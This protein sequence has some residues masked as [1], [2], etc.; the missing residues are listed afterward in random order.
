MLTLST[1]KIMGLK[2]TATKGDK[3]KKKEVAEEIAKLEHELE[4]RHQNEL[5]QFEALEET[6]KVDEVAND[7]EATLEV[8]TRVTKAQKRR[9]KKQIKD[10][11]RD[12][13]VAEQE[14]ANLQGARHL[15]TESIRKLLASRGLTFHDVPS[16]GHCMYVA[17]AHQLGADSPSV[18][19]LRKTAADF[20]RSHRDDFMPFMDNVVDDVQFLK[21]CQE[22][23]STAAWGGQLELRALSQGLGRAIEVLQSEGRPVLIGEEFLA[24]GKPT[25]TLTYHRHMFGLGEHYNSVQPLP[26]ETDTCD[27]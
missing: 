2:K 13:A 3:K 4:E 27:L 24:G 25:V 11:E 22:T 26:A 20:M 17:I 10:R 6:P 1:A 15:E 21:Y 5:Q 18:Q 8:T 19:Q 12:L 23:E 9:D 14:Q 16:D 7:L